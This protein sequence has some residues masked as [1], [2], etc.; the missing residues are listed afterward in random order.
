M[1]IVVIGT[2]GI[3]DIS[4]GVETHCEELYPRIAAMGHNV[5]VIR[6]TCYVD[7]H[8]RLDE[9]RGVRLRDVYA[10]RKKQL[11]A[12]VHTFLATLSAWRL[13]PDVLHVHAIGPSLLIPMARLLGMKV[14]MTNHGPDY[15]RQKWGR[16]AKTMLKLGEKVGTK[17]ANEIIAISSDI[18]QSLESMYGRI[19]TNLIY[20]GVNM[21]RKSKSIDYIESLGLSP[22]NYIVA[23]GRFVKE[24]GFHDLIEAFEKIDNE[25]YKLVIA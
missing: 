14:V 17:W 6:R 21:P 23:L 25:D 9:Y 13:H 12:L 4:G 15:N 22:K 19:N 24:K 10:P 2:R 7:E 8:N 1:K 5:T 3:P 18:A 20:N 16:I 11:E